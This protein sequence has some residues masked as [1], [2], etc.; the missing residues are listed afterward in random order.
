MSAVGAQA[1]QHIKGVINIFSS[2]FGTLM[3]FRD[4][5]YTGKAAPS[6]FL[7]SSTSVVPESFPLSCWWADKDWI[8]IFRQTCPLNSSRLRHLVWFLVGLGGR[9]RKDIATATAALPIHVHLRTRTSTLPP[10][11]TIGHKRL[12]E[13]WNFTILLFLFACQ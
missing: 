12:L 4:L 13:S 9:K 8:L 11:N 3:A 6:H 10:K 7:P 1:R 5:D 2:Q